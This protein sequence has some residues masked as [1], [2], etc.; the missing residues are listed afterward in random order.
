MAGSSSTT[1]M[2]LVEDIGRIVGG[3]APGHEVR[4]RGEGREAGG[5][6]GEVGGVAGP[7]N[8][9]VEPVPVGRSRRSAFR[10]PHPRRGPRD[11]RSRTCRGL[12]RAR[13]CRPGPSLGRDRRGPSRRRWPRPPQKMARIR[14]K[15]RKMKNSVAKKPKM[16]KPGKPQPQPA[17]AVDDDRCDDGAAVGR[18]LGDRGGQ[19][20]LV[21]GRCDRAAADGQ[22]HEQQEDREDAG[23]AR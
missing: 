5:Q 11:A 6:A 15:T 3:C 23:H 2:V 10:D 21:G 14:P 1:R 12:D 17:V 20:G 22:D 9:P 4:G 13:G 16:P 19:A 7:P 18:D 8:V